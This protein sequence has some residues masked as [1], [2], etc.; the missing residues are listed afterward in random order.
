MLIMIKDCVSCINRVI[1]NTML[2]KL[3][4]YNVKETKQIQC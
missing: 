4:K 3:N 2:K 1:R